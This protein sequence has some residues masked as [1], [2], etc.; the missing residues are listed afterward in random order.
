MTIGMQIFLR[1][2]LDAEYAGIEQI[3][4]EQQ[5]ARRLGRPSI[6]SS[7]SKSCSASGLALTLIWMLIF[8]C[9]CCGCS[10][11][12]A[13]GFSN[14]R[15]L[16][17]WPRTLSCGG[18]LL[19]LRL[20]RRAAIGRCHETAPPALARRSPDAIGGVA[21]TGAQS[22]T[23]TPNSLDPRR[24][25]ACRLRPRRCVGN[26]SPLVR[27]EIDHVRAGRRA[28]RFTMARPNARR[29]QCCIGGNS[30]SKPRMSVRKPGSTSRIPP[31]TVRKPLPSSSH[32]A[33]A[34]RSPNA[35]RTRATSPRPARRTT[36]MPVSEVRIVSASA[37]RT[38]S[39][40][41]TAMKIGDFHEGEH[42]QPENC[43]FHQ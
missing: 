42:E 4:A 7:T 41:A 19:A 36:D 16:M 33:D 27:R 40:S 5:H 13:F 8:G 14:D 12:G 24:G 29:I 26:A 20:Q 38:P 15:S 39:L 17:Y 1:H 43:P 28:P 25:L 37:A 18:C 32:T 31:S 23:R 11:R 35:S 21:N 6:L 10:E 34:V 22:A 30:S 3:E 2:V 9:C